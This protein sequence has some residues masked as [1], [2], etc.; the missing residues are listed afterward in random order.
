MGVNGRHKNEEVKQKVRVGQRE[1]NCLQNGQY[2]NDLVVNYLLTDI[3]DKTEIMSVI[4]S[5]LFANI[6]IEPLEN[7]APWLPDMRYDWAFPACVNE[8]WSLVVVEH[9]NLSII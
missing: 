3:N 6:S 4:P 5:N 1:R 8:H 7:I 2:L 9:R